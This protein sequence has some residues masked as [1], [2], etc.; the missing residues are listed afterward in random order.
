MSVQAMARVW[1]LALPHAESFVLLAVADH[2]DHLGDNIKPSISLIAW[3]TGY[4]ERQVMRILHNLVELGIL[5]IQDQRVGRPTVYQ[6]D[7]SAG[8]PKR[9][10]QRQNVT[11]DNQSP[12]TPSQGNQRQNVTSDKRRNVRGTPD[13]AMSPTPDIAMSHKPSLTIN[14]PSV[15]QQQQQQAPDESM[16]DDEAKQAAVLLLDK[17]RKERNGRK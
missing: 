2:A 1:D 17:F 12:V 3:K 8:T 10:Y 4:S 11:S 16:T 14:K 9:P 15:K 13:I 7:L 5:Q 6:M